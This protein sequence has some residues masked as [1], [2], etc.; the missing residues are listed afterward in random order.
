MTGNCQ[1]LIPG[2][3]CQKVV[4]CFWRES[5]PFRETTLWSGI[6]KKQDREVDEPQNNDGYEDRNQQKKEKT[7]ILVKADEITAQ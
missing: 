2:L 5:Q 6:L 1:N 7:M 4:S 3:N